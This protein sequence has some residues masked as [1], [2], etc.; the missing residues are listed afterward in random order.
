MNDLFVP[1]ILTFIPNWN[2]NSIPIDLNGNEINIESTS[3]IIFWCFDLMLKK[4]GHIHLLYNVTN[5]CI[6][7]AQNVFN[8][9]EKI[10]PLISIWFKQNK[11]DELVFLYSDFV[12]L[13]K[14]SCNNIWELWLKFFS[15][16][17]PN[18]WMI[19]ITTSIIIYGFEYFINST[20]NSITTIME[21]FSKLMEN[22]NINEIS[23]IAYY[24]STKI[25]PLNQKNN[26]IEIPS[27]NPIFF[28]K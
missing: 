9:L 8:L 17:S 13:F 3:S 5:Q 6:L 2:E 27:F 15:S 11:L 10:T 4:T 16:I 21:S 12:L 26:I 23:I 14:R 25:P 28:S 24:I 19:Y 18:S 20:D 1:L 7:L 22:L